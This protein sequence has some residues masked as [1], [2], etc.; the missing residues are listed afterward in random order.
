MKRYITILVALAA[1]HGVA[2]AQSVGA[3]VKVD[4]WEFDYQADSVRV[5]LEFNFSDLEIAANQSVVFVPK[6][7][8]GERSVELPTVVVRGRGGA[9]SYQRA[10]TLGNSQSLED[11]NEWYGTPYQI[12]ENYGE[13]KQQSLEYALA[14][15]IRAMDGGV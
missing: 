6:I 2:E 11:Y 1:L 10:L 9:R 4:L 8:K 5:N 12:V 14:P 3:G 13:Q 15:A 7:F